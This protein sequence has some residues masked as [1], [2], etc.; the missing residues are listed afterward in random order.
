LEACQRAHKLLIDHK[1]PFK[2]PSD[3]FAEMVKSD[4]QMR[5]I[6]SDLL[7]EKK[8]LTQIDE[9]KKKRD[10]K[11][12]GKQVQVAKI[13]ERNKKSKQ[14]MATV[15]KW[16]KARE[17]GETE[18]EIP[19]FNKEN[20]GTSL[21][22]R[23]PKQNNDK[24]PPKKTISKKRL[25]K[26]ERYGPK[27]KTDKKNSSASSADMSSFSV[28]QHRNGKTQNKFSGKKNNWKQ[29]RPGKGK[30]QKNH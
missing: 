8:R 14:E 21:K 4:E 7:E 20:K 6:K 17:K 16:R 3:Y 19:I 22:Q 10:M 9:K 1:I 28:A 23:N 27:H 15:S 12:F 13:Q 24:F 11:N 18:E 5:K 26:N 25:W 29:K 30:R 2:R